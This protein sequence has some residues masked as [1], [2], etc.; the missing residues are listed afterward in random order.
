MVKLNNLSAISAAVLL[1]VS[2][3]ARAAPILANA[4]NVEKNV[5][6][7]DV[8]ER[9]FAHEHVA[10]ITGASIKVYDDT[11][12]TMAVGATNAGRIVIGD[13]NTERVSIEDPLDKTAVVSSQRESQISINAA[14]IIVKGN[15]GS[16]GVKV[17]TWGG[18]YD[19]I[20]YDG[21]S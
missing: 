20:C 17:E 8:I 19:W 13:E 21:F 14:N 18:Y 2:I 3:G 1:S 5:N 7:E 10:K 9:I 4:S 16:Q 15:E 12:G 11:A 6:A